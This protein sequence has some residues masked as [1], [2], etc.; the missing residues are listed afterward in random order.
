MPNQNIVTNRVDSVAVSY[1]TRIFVAFEFHMLIMALKKCIFS[2][3]TTGGLCLRPVL[4]AD[5]E[6]LK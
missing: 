4:R 1:K 2:S 3:K 5:V 6:Y